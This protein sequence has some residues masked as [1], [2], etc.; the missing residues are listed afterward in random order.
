MSHITHLYHLAGPDFV[1][2]SQLGAPW[3]PTYT[4]AD[5]LATT[6][7]PGAAILGSY[8]KAL[9]MRRKAHQMSALFSGRHPISNAIVPGGVTVDPTTTQVAAFDALLNEI[10]NFINLTYIPDVVTVAGAFTAAWG[11]GAGCG[12]LLSY[13]EFPLDNAGTNSLLAAGTSLTF[14][15][16]NAAGVNQAN[17]VEYVTYSYYS[18]YPGD[19]AGTAYK[20][21]YAGVT[22]PDPTLTKANAYSWMKAP[23]YL[24]GG[25]T[26]TVMEVGPLARM[27]I[28]TLTA[29]PA[30]V[31]EAGSTP[32]LGGAITSPYTCA[33]LVTAALGVVGKGVGDL[34]SVLGRHA[35]RA[36]EC[37]F[38]ADAM[39]T[40]L[41]TDLQIGAGNEV[42][43]YKALPKLAK[44]AGLAEAPRG[45]L[46]HWIT[47]DQKKIAA[48]QCVV[49]TTW[50]GSPKDG[51]GNHGPIEAALIG[52]TLPDGTG[53][54][55]DILE[56]LRIVHP[57][58]VCVACAVH[59]ITPDGKDLVKYNLNPDGSL[60][61]LD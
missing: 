52:A 22:T 29:N 34:F 40:W 35:A 42:Y 1:D 27:A 30:T 56:I 5:L 45:A 32:L 43:T 21:P 24:V 59:L 57:F 19:T 31:T 9:E 8:V 33:D 46:G 6:S 25:T 44:G 14:G 11:L 15:A 49:P 28:S 3:D 16:T 47:I 48:Y 51:L 36:L 23:R 13:G 60:T 7:G 12:N 2:A 54:N 39:H 4:G 26:P 37:K 38:V 17:V 55:A 41:N 53:T 61:R 10:R 18:N 50:N 20:Q 58:D